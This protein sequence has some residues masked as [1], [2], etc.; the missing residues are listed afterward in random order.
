[1]FEWNA[2]EGR[3]AYGRVI[4]SRAENVHQIAVKEPVGTDRGVLALERSDNYAFPENKRRSRGGLFRYH[5]AGGGNAGHSACHRKDSDRGPDCR[6]GVLSIVFGD[7]VLISKMLIE[8]SVI[9]GITFTGSTVVGK[10]TRGLAVQGMKRMTLELGGHAPVVVFDDVNVD[11]V[12]KA[13]ANCKISKFRAGLYA[14]RHA[15]MSRNQSMIASWRNSPRLPRRSLSADG[16]DPAT[17]MGPLAHARRVEAM[18]TFVTDARARGIKVAA[19]GGRCGNQGFFFQPTLLV[20]IDNESMAANVE[21]F[22]PLASTNSIQ[23][24]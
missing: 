11:A 13:A 4:P 24:V 9:R 23:L 16:F 12:A 15:S 17:T 22:G 10:A 20:D 18:E 8:S 2:E 6:T 14:R 3:R 19:G 1:M 21:P 7:P 5:Q